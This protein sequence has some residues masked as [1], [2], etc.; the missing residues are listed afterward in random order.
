MLRLTT[1]GRQTGKER[2]AILAYLEEG[3]DLILMAMNGWAAPAPAWYLNLQAHPDVRVDMPDGKREV[4]A[5]VADEDERA[6]L[7]ERWAELDA[8]LDAYA[9]ALSHETPVVVLEPRP[10][11][12]PQ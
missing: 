4:H 8:D 1:V 10:A 7:W 5:R 6:R 3:P 2:V 12:P 11:T 9:A